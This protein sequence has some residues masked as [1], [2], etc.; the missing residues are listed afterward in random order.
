MSRTVPTTAEEAM[1]A[2][3]AERMLRPETIESFGIRPDHA[4]RAWAY[5][6]RGGTRYKAWDR[7]ASGSKYWS[8][9]GTPNQLYGLDRIPRGTRE[10]WLVNGEPSVWACFQAGVPAVCGIA[11]EGNLPKDAA[12][13]LMAHGVRHVRIC[14][15]LDEAGE[16]GALRAAASLRPPLLV[17]ICRL[18]AALG[19]GG[20]VG[21]LYSSLGGDDEAFRDALRSLP[22]EPY[23]PPL[24]P[25]SP[26]RPVRVHIQD[27]DEWWK[28]QEVLIA[29]FSRY[30]HLRA[31]G[32]RWVCRCPFHE[33]KNP[34]LVLYPDGYG[35]CFG[36]GW[37][38]DA[39]K[40]IMALERVPFKEAVRMAAQAAGRL[41][42]M[43]ERRRR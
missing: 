39:V 5:P 40:A 2:L 3:Q 33:D 27:S 8:S 12:S 41:N 32:P 14:F 16:T 7:G 23:L 34:S 42:P 28:T 15:D 22:G 9:P 18:P 36:C 24:R 26:P 38:G 11:G 4:A 1:K 37:H 35:H 20:D 17:T 10:I 25:P 29:V 19:P 13:T 21:D 31:T 43:H 6:V 30:S